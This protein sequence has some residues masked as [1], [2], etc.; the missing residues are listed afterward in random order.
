MTNQTWEFREFPGPSPSGEDNAVIFLNEPARQGRGEAT[1][2]LRNDGS[3]GLFYLAPGDLGTSTA[4]TWESRE[5]PSPDGE[6]NA[7]IFL[8]EPARQGPGEATATLRN[9]GSAGLLFLAPGS[10][11]ASTTQTWE[12]GEFAGPKQAVDFLNEPARQGPGQATVTPRNNGTV[13]LL[14]LAP[15]SLG[16]EHD[17]DLALQGIPGPRRGNVRP[18][19][20]ERLSPAGGGRS[21]RIRAQRRVRR[22]LLPRARVKLSTHTQSQRAP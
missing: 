8:N 14:Y 16:A 9:D 10:L 12:S 4:P 20:P 3:A 19:V 6:K 2:T 7:V 21:Q 15:G 1:A 22:D 18:G 13:G 5:F 17:P 11:G